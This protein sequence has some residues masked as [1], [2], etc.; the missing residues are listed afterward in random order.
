[1]EKINHKQIDTFLAQKN[2]AFIG[3]SRTPNEF[4]RN[5]YTEFN[6]RNY[7][8][9]PVNPNTAE[10]EGKTC[11]ASIKDVNEPVDAAIIFVPPDKMSSIPA[12]CI[13]KGIKNIW[14]Y[15]PKPAA[16]NAVIQD[17]LGKDD[18]NVI[19]GYCPLMFISDTHWFHKIH[20]FFVKLSGKYPS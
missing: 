17:D 16:K 13:N 14:I 15:D 10:I 1:M 11:Y 4:S 12:D 19:T 3:L 18:I 9:I 2:I 20:G 6:K 8:T 5:V 7:N